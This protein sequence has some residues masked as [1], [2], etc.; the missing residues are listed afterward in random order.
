M[1][2]KFINNKHE[3]VRFLITYNTFWLQVC[4]KYNTQLAWNYNNYTNKINKI[5]NMTSWEIYLANHVG[6][7]QLFLSNSSTV[8]KKK[9]LQNSETNC[10]RY[11]S[12]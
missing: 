11:N 2:T 12:S 7:S 10:Q 1:R 4:L 8:I 9:N 3:L 6:L 5:K